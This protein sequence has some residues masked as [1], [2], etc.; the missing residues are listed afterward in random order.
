MSEALFVS[1][2]CLRFLRA[3]MQFSCSEKSTWMDERGVPGACEVDASR[4][5]KD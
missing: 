3:R 1:Q 4:E 5:K 2:M